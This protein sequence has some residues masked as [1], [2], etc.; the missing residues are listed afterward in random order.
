VCCLIGNDDGPVEFNIK[1]TKYMLIVNFITICSLKMAVFWDAVLCSVV[2]ID[3]SEGLTVSIIREAVS[4]SEMLVSIY[5]S[6]HPRRQ[7]S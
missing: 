1:L 3:V 7:A 6:Q 4:T 5:I 2:D